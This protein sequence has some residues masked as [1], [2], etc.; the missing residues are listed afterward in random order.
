MLCGT[1]SQVSPH[2]VNG[3]TLKVASGARVRFTSYVYVEGITI[4]TGTNDPSEITPD[5]G[6]GGCFYNEVR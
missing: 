3:G 6:H 2:A 5:A 4:S 1:P